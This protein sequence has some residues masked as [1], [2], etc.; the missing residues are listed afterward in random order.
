M[1]YEREQLDS[2]EDLVIAYDKA[3]NDKER[4]EVV[5]AAKNLF[6]YDAG[7]IIS[8][9]RYRQSLKGVARVPQPRDN[10]YS[11]TIT[12]EDVNGGFAGINSGNNG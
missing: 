4:K 6:G 5:D 12:Q 7:L 1:S 2:L 11:E 8:R 3:R 9:V 10:Y